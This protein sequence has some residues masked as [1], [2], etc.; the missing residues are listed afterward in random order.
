M[1]STRKLR[2]GPLPNAD[3]VKITFLCPIELKDDL[4]RYAALHSQA[5]GLKV[6]AIV[7]IPHMLQAFVRKDRTFNRIRREGIRP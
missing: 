7:L 2:L 6:D 4:E 1:T 5:Y 3:T